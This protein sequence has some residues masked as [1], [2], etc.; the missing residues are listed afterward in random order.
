MNGYK[1]PFCSNASANCGICLGEWSGS[2]NHLT[3][4]QKVVALLSQGK[5]TLMM[6]YRSGSN[7]H[8][9]LSKEKFLDVLRFLGTLRMVWMDPVKNRYDVRRSRKGWRYYYENLSSISDVR[10]MRIISLV[11]YEPIGF[12]DESFVIEHGER[13]NTFVCNGRAWKVVQIEDGKVMVEPVDDIES[14]IPV[15]PG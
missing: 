4:A 9:K 2:I 10:R 8:H 14:A 11:E 5:K 7:P 3:P 13:G 15:A 12:L 6:G 1:H